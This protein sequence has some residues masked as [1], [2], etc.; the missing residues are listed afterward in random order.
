MNGTAKSGRKSRGSRYVV[1]V[2]CLICIV[3]F[4][5]ISVG[6]TQRVGHH[7]YYWSI[8]SVPI[9]RLAVPL[10]SVCVRMF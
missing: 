6:T 5:S 7:A 9:I 4:T 8:F 2:S 10:Q 1:I 3:A